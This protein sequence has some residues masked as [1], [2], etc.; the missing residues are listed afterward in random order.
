MIPQYTAAS[1]VSHNKQLSTPA[2]VDSIE[3]SQGQEDH[4]SMGANAAVKAFKVME[5][6]ERILAIELY[7]AAQALEFRRP[8][9]TSPILEKMLQAYR[10]KVPF[11]TNDKV[12]YDDIN[13]T[14]GFLRTYQEK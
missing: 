4:V 10:Q 8:L 9:K 6:L 3:S 7:S 5:N 12:M 1:M 13:E 14:V 2:S 11:I